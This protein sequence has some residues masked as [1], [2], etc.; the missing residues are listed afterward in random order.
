[1]TAIDPG[2][3]TEPA[4]I[5]KGAFDF[6]WNEAARRGGILAL[7]LAFVA[8]TGM[9]NGLNDR[10]LIDPILSLGYLSLLWLP[11]AFGWL[12]GNEK[13]LEG[14]ARTK[15]GL[16][17]VVRGDVIGFVGGLGLSLLVILINAFDLRD[18]LVN[19]SPQTLAVLQ[20][21][22]GQGFGIIA[23]PILGAI[24]GAAGASLHLLPQRIRRATLAALA[25]VLV[26]AIF[27]TFI[28]DLFDFTEDL[29]YENQ[30]G[31][32]ILWAIIL[33]V[34]A[35]GASIGGA[36]RKVGQV[37]TNY[38]QATGSAKTTQTALYI[39]LAS[40]A[41][42]V[43][44]MFT[45]KITQELLANIGIFLLLAL[46]LNIVVGLAGILDL[47]YVAFF[48]VGGYTTAVLTSPNRG[49]DWPEWFP[50]MP[51]WGALMVTI[52]VAA[53]VGLFIGAPV[54]RM[55]G[56]YLAIVTLGF[57]EIIRI[58]FL[59]D[60]LNGYFNGAQGITNVPPADFGFA[61]VKGTDPRSVF[62]LVLVFAAI[63]IYVSWR[64]ER[65]RLGRAWMAI[66]EDESVAEAM[67]INTVNV[68]LMAFV[69]GAV[70]ASFSGAIFAAKVGSIFPTSF[71]ILVSI[72]ILVVVIVGGMGN[73]I[74]VIVGAAVLIG[75]LGGPKQ[76]GLL[77]EFS[78]YK[79]LIY[80]ALL[81]VMMLQRPEG[82]VPNV[83]RSRE[84]HQEEFLQD[85]WLKGEVD[86]AKADGDE[87]NGGPEGALA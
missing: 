29:L 71:L 55:R 65:S 82:L 39:F 61:Q 28:V 21:D 75:V 87:P 85:A 47:G 83:R 51:W 4:P 24:L 48:A 77:A 26:F 49:E 56:D 27:E 80:G 59:S 40:V 12:S 11:F 73:I 38:Q 44:P 42:I 78:E 3:A 13:V 74:G 35:F 20:F 8:L 52:V 5:E 79:L 22:R 9:P 31:L 30:G 18:P 37:R 57:G 69:V 62:Y 25:T 54:I 86:D 41:M 43:I 76:P 16:R 19:W 60:W 64:L 68:K 33:F 34:V 72:I 53:L 23:W 14:M 67:G 32:K 15:R 66:R 6:D 10:L 36:G 81:I 50:T 45:G 58:L 2:T 63:S 84:L 1:M 46:G 17:D 70:L 7:A